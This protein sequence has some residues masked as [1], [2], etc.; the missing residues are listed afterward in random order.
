MNSYRLV[1]GD[2]ITVGFLNA[3]SPIIYIL[4][5][6]EYIFLIFVSSDFSKF[7]IVF[8]ISE[9]SLVFML[10]NLAV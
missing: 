7:R 2:F 4:C 10:K 8:V 6:K 5:T 9:W 3:F 1:M